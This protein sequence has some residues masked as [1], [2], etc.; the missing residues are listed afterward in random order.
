M[1]T[2][3][4]A[5]LALAA[6]CFDPCAFA[7]EQT[8]I[9]AAP[10]ASVTTSDSAKTV[11]TLPE[12]KLQKISE[13]TKVITP[14]QLALMK[15]EAD[16]VEVIAAPRIVWDQSVDLTRV[17]VALEAEKQRVGKMG[18]YQ[19]PF[20]DMP[21]PDAIRMI[22]EVSGSKFIAPSRK[23]V[24]D[25]KVT[26]RTRSN[27][28]ALLD[29]LADTYGFAY[30]M[31]DGI[32]RFYEV[33]AGELVARTYKLKYTDLAV[34]ELTPNSLNNQ[35]SRGGSTPVTAQTG[36][37]SNIQSSASKLVD[38]ITEILSRPTTGLKMSDPS[39]PP[40]FNHYGDGIVTKGTVKYVSDAFS[41]D[42]YA[43][44]QQHEYIKHWLDSVDV[45]QRLVQIEA[46]FVEVTTGDDQ[47]LGLDTSGLASTQVK[48]S[49]LTSG[50][51]N[52]QNFSKTPWP[53][54]AIIE[55]SDL[56]VT[57]NAL[58]SNNKA[59]ILQNPTAI[60]L[61][62]RKVNLGSTRQV[63]IQSANNQLQSGAGNS[64]TASIDY[65][66]IGTK[67]TVL[68]LIVEADPAYGNRPAVRLD[69]T[70]AISS[71]TGTQNIGGNDYPVVSS[72]NYAYTVI[73]PDQHSLA[74]AGLR[75]TRQKETKK[76]TPIFGWIPGVRD[77]PYVGNSTETNNFDAN[78]L[79]F[80]TPRILGQ[81]DFDAKSRSTKLPDK[82][83]ALR[84]SGT[85]VNLLG[86]GYNENREK[87][88]L[89]DHTAAPRAD[90]GSV[91]GSAVDVASPDMV[92]YKPT[93]VAVSDS[94]GGGKSLS[95]DT[96]RAMNEGDYALARR[97]LNEILEK[98]PSNEDA[99]ALLAEVNSAEARNMVGSPN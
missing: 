65:V 96:V 38:G 10:G 18:E 4:I 97:R 25:T 78:L 6:F 42:V 40:E 3:S 23:G 68:P 21:L 54:N 86:T 14:E 1:K 98:D 36:S 8:P 64:N 48:A 89:P 15:R 75:E 57:L 77:I 17:N 43:T 32:F 34:A 87:V 94:S 51:I 81:K 52:F 19:F 5:S 24:F 26:L 28:I 59:T 69:V 55:V 11:I 90:T 12:I 76:L 56:S 84:A 92:R 50:A 2:K 58:M 74:I 71:Q 41:L 61:N 93:S 66:E 95:G 85:S 73:V 83:D 82:D 45:A 67:M 35:L 20:K 39:Q 30:D 88:L 79:A 16:K 29:S 63:P 44:R 70:L 22:C 62:N 33:N 9:V 46:Q 7:Q 99:K 27:P 49:G 37:M 47:N 72:R 31:K 60:T 53:T 91:Q 80:I 13:T